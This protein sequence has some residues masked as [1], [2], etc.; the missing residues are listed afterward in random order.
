MVLNVHSDASYLTEPK[1]R[2][3][4][5]GHFFM[6]EDNQDPKNN[7]MTI[8]KWPNCYTVI[9][10]LRVGFF[11]SGGVGFKGCAKGQNRTL[12]PVH[13]RYGCVSPASLFLMGKENPM[14]VK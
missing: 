10:F 11:E 1:A 14:F 12:V 3:R 5:G 7:E 9:S 6:S 2:I 13:I 8:P 4:A